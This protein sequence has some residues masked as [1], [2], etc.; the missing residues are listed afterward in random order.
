MSP[1]APKGFK[2]RLRAGQSQIGCYVTL[3]SPDVVE[4][5]ARAGM[6]YVI[7]DRQ[8]ASPDWQTL[9]HMIRAA[10]AAGCAP[11]VRMDTKDPETIL[12]VLELGAE[13]INLPLVETAAEIR[14]ATDAIFYP[15][16]GRRSACGHTRAGGYNSRRS[17]FGE[18]VRRQHARVALWVAVESPEAVA[19]IGEIAASDPG[20]DVIGVGRGDLSAALGLYGQVDH[21]EVIAATERAMAE[22]GARSAG[23]SAMSIMVQKPEDIGR[24]LARGSRLVTYAADVILLMDAA[25]SAVE[26]FRSASQSGGLHAR[27]T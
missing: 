8:H 18:H 20:P 14:R 23:R 17:E 4:L 21:P 3:P 26:A 5:L 13:G 7:I 1:A 19:R 27:A 25:R 10:E 12:K 15:P 24:W 2:A 22:V 9:A 16:V 11:L 6:D